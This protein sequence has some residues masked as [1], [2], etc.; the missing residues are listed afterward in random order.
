VNVRSTML[1]VALV[2][3]LAGC[4]DQGAP[5]GPS[6]GAASEL[7]LA[8]VVEVTNAVD[9]G[10]GSFREAIQTANLEA[11]VTVVRFDRSV[12]VVDLA[13]AVVYT[14][15][16]SLRIE[17]RGATLAG[18]SGC[19]CDLLVAT[20]G[21]DLILE[22]LTLRDAPRTGL[23]M[24]VPDGATG[25]VGL[26]LRD[27]TVRDNGLHGIHID[28]Q[29]GDATGGDSPAGIVLVIA[30]S[31]VSGNGFRSGFSDFDGIR[32]DEGGAGDLYATLQGSL[33]L[34]NAGDG[35]ELDERGTGSV[36]AD[37][38]H[39]SFDD[40]GEQPQNPDDLED[41]FDVDEADEG[42]IEVRVVHAT[43][44]GNFDEGF[45]L[46]E[47]G[48][49]G[50]RL[51][52]SQAVASGNL[53]EGIKLTE[54][55]ETE[56]GGGLLVELINVDASN[57]QA[58]DGIHLEEFGPGDV[59][60]RVVHSTL[61]GNDGDGVKVDQQG[62]GGGVLRL[63]NVESLANGGDPVDVSGVEVVRVP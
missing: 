12:G 41:G 13:S 25:D 53:D 47:E 15:S 20:G 2:L 60:A 4:N 14:G 57:S 48:P 61:N 28:D 44:S 63:Q 42:D 33:F 1:F 46:D 5:I 10:P 55:A 56:A 39:T 54:D 32:V 30:A 34:E 40:N 51:F 49:G 24:D 52:M 27:V 23:V 3:S 18:A 43:A 6:G 45:D 50:I 29:S 16:Q 22:N 7:A 19:D 9:A 59:M 35:L 38:K 58:D 37:V 26:A 36:W 8:A 31:S 21:A 62:T 17:G 11:S